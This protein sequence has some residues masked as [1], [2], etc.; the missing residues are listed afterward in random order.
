M[1]FHTLLRERAEHS[2][3]HPVRLEALTRD[4]LLLLAVAFESIIASAA[5]KNHFQISKEAEAVAEA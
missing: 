2:L 1:A 5:L 4:E 3:D